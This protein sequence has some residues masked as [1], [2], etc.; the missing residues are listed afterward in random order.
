MQPAH[1]E[2]NSLLD[3][4][5]RAHEQQLTDQSFAI[6]LCGSAAEHA[7][8]KESDIDYLVVVEQETAAV[9]TTLAEIRAALEA[10][11]GQP[12]SNTA[13]SFAAVAALDQTLGTID[14]KAAQALLEARTHPSRI[15]STGNFVIPKVSPA[16]LQTYL[17]HDFWKLQALIRKQLARMEFAPQARETHLTKLLKLCAIALKVRQQFLEAST[18]MHDVPPALTRLRAEV[19]ALK[20]APSPAST[21]VLA[22]AD[23]VL[24]LGPADF[25]QAS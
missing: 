21:H 20:S 11:L 16:T 4:I 2:P 14:G 5:F 9:L 10:D 8:T 19:A 1:S 24:A 23:A 3:R 7:L 15:A 6:V 12:V 13:V 22:V 18:D 25:H 17:M